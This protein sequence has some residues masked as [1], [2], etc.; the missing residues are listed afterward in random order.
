MKLIAGFVIVSLFV[1]QSL[2]AA[3]CKIKDGCRLV[4]SAA[5]DKWLT[6]AEGR[7]Q[8]LQACVDAAEFGDTCMLKSGAYHEEIFI[9]EKHNLTIRSENSNKR[10]TL[11]GTIVLRP[12]NDEG[13]EEDEIMTENGEIKLVCYGEIDIVDDKHPFQLF[14]KEKKN[15]EMDEIMTENGEIKLV[16]Y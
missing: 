9:N 4:D 6:D 2:L 13:W 1:L 14:V 8:S 15:H 12:K 11:D 3:K 7:Y 10:A 5:S 16:C